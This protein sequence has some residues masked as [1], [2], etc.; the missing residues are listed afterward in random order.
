MNVLENQGWGSLRCVIGGSG[1]PP[2]AQLTANRIPL[3]RP[4]GTENLKTPAI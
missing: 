1:S 4:Y 3:Q 2:V